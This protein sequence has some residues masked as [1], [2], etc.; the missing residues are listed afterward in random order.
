MPFS[1]DGQRI[2]RRAAGDWRGLEAVLRF[3]VLG[4]LRVEAGSIVVPVTSPRQRAVLA[5]LLRHANR[6]VS[7]AG[8]I[9]QVWGEGRPASAGGLVHTYIWQLRRL[10]AA[11]EPAAGRPWITRQPGGYLLR[12]AEGELDANV[13]EQLAM[14]GLDALAAGDAAAASGHLRRALGLWS[15]EPLADLDLAGAAAAECGRLAELRRQAASARIEAGLALGQHAEAA[16]Q[17]RALIA[18]DPLDEQLHAHLMTALSQSGRRA[19]ALQVY[20][21]ARRLLASELGLEPG[22]RLRE[23]QAAILRGDSIP[24]P[25]TSRPAA[26]HLAGPAASPAG[27]CLRTPHAS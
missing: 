2:R 27:A 20:T 4:S 19:E 6:S 17:L 3:R 12:V 9:D 13:F 25:A 1:Y 26:G 10:L 8:L 16:A 15:G 18:G 22:P 5:V 14:A 23:L 21:Q 7:A 24:G 11:H